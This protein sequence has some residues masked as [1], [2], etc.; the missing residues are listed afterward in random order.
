[1]SGHGEVKSWSDGMTTV[2]AE[3][4]TVIRNVR[5]EDARL[6]VELSDG[7]IL[8]TPVRWYPRLAHATPAQRANW[9]LL[10]G[11]EGIHWPDVDEDLSLE[12]ML[13]GRAAPGVKK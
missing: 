2:A 9:Q 5:F 8:G 6:I 4:L 1:L 12:G 3:A 11:G 10:A 13:A 7:R